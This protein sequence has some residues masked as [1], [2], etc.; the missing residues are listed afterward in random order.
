MDH[1]LMSISSGHCKVD[2]FG[3][4]LLAGTIVLAIV[5]YVFVVSFHRYRYLN[6]QL[7]F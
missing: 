6:G 2:G 3:N 5:C 7:P 4:I 1:A